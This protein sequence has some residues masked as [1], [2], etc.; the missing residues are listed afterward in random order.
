MSKSAVQNKL[1][2]FTQWLYRFSIVSHLHS[3]RIPA[4]K[5][6]GELLY[7]ERRA[8]CSK[9]VPMYSVTDLSFLVRAK[10]L[11]NGW[12][13]LSTH[14]MNYL[15]VIESIGVYYELYETHHS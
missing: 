6:D 1:I 15:I 5:A 13:V 14:F 4:W 3:R 11:A 10:C 12:Y 8:Q 2:V 9:W 7:E